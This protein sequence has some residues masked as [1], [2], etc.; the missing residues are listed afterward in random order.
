[1]KIITEEQ[2]KKKCEQY[3]LQFNK[4]H[5][6]G[7]Y[8][9]CRIELIC[10]QCANL[11]DYPYSELNKRKTCLCKDCLA[12]SY[13]LSKDTIEKR[14]IEF[15]ASLVDIS[16]YKV[17][18]DIVDIKCKC[19]HIFKLRIN[20]IPKCKEICCKKCKGLSTNSDI[21]EFCRTNNINLIQIKQNNKIQI[22]CSVCKSKIYKTL[23][24]LKTQK[25]PGLCQKCSAGTREPNYNNINEMKAWFESHG[26]TAD[27]SNYIG[28][29]Y[30]IPIVCSCGHRF[31]R[32][33]NSISY[34]KSI[35]CQRCTK[36]QNYIERKLE[37]AIT[38]FG[39][40]YEINYRGMIS[41]QEI[42]FYFPKKKLGIEINGSY[43]HSDIL[44][45]RNYHLD[46]TIK[47]EKSGVQ[48]IHF[49]DYEVLYKLDIIKSM[50]G[51]RLDKAKKIYA[52]QCTVQT[53]DK[54]RANNFF[55]ETHIQGPCGALFYYGLILDGQL[56]ACMS[57]GKPRFNKA[58]EYELIRFSNRL[59]YTVIGGASKLFKAFVKD[60]NPTAILSYA[61]RRFSV[62]GLYNK[63]GFSLIG[64]SKP[65][66]FYSNGKHYISRI[67][68]QKHKLITLLG[69][70]Y[71]SSLS[72]YEN[73]L[74]AK[75]FR[76][77]DCGNLVYYWRK[78]D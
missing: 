18:T 39:E 56:L 9:T 13:R 55:K 46:K 69:D 12:N 77:W 43:W 73:M 32:S 70:K 1:M 45:D 49:F 27:L 17:S 34:Y 54:I 26:L 10:E 15:G 36:K 62:G 60:N 40:E 74:K 3:N 24:G 72:E 11:I 44:K 57:F 30:K 47:A 14:L 51:A 68:A 61:N 76:I 2:A 38:D 21:E 22:E 65:N 31:K 42:D 50:I 16:Q 64:N 63:L 67:K 35:L 33:W 29:A 23:R 59:G 25:S 7:N 58:Y 48:L 28:A 75:Y 53:I 41:P 8:K 37:D 5:K 4:I 66:Y 52:R 71:D 78:Y 19:G 20:D 6:P